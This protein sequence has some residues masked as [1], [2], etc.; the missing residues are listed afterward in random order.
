M[1]RVDLECVCCEK[2]S[3]RFALA[4]RRSRRKWLCPAPEN[5][6]ISLRVLKNVRGPVKGM[7]AAKKYSV[8][9]IV[10]KL[11]EHEKLQGQGLTIPHW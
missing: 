2:L 10:A 4:A 9:Q 1:S 11:R 7:A 5:W 3:S 8:G 6:S